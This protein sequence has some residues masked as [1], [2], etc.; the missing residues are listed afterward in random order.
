[1]FEL[2]ARIP[3]A[4]KWKDGVEKYILRRAAEKRLPA[5]TAYRPKAGFPV[6]VRE[7][8]RRDP[9]RRRAE[10]TLF[11]PLSARF[12]DQALLRGYWTQFQAGNGIIWQIPYAAYVF[13]TWAREYGI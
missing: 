2:A 9:F 8:L 5:E 11:S 13:L 12:F 6:P 10:E 1:M 3:S 4:L 7:W